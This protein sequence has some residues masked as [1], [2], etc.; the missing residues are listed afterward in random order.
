MAEVIVAID[1]PMALTPEN[2]GQPRV[3][4]GAFLHADIPGRPITEAVR[5]DR[6]YLRAGDTVWVMT[7]EDKL[8][9]RPVT[10]AWRGA[11]EVLI[12]HGLAAGDRI[13]TTP[14]STVADGMSL[15]LR[16]QGAQG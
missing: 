4:L 7:P 2:A 12:S 5:L 16:E 14:L 8:E 10:V 13:I 15:R 6:T 9:I 11:D 1:D 3:L